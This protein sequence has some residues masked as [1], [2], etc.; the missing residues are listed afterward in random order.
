MFDGDTSVTKFKIQTKVLMESGI[1]FTS[2][3][4][5][6]YLSKRNK[7]FVTFNPFSETFA[8]DLMPRA[9]F[10]A[11]LTPINTGSPRS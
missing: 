9:G 11:I 6:D 7:L 1:N 10:R 8:S 4:H 3:L 5:S 2:S